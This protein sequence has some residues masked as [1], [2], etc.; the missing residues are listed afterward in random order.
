MKEAF[1][2]RFA[3]LSASASNWGKTN[4]AKIGTG[5]ALFGV[6]AIVVG[7][8]IVPHLAANAE[9]VETVMPRLPIIG[10]ASDVTDGA[11]LTINGQKV[12]LWGITA[13]G[14]TTDDGQ[15]SAAYLAALVANHPLTCLQTG[16]LSYDRTVV[17]C[18]DP[19]NRD[20][21]E[22]MVAGGWAT[23]R[24]EYSARYYAPSEDLARAQGRGLH[25]QTSG[26]SRAAVSVMADIESL[27][28][29]PASPHT[30][31]AHIVPRLDP[32]ASR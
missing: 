31:G 8:A 10:P 6:G 15:K 7:S 32:L 1:F 9:A 21:G 30:S 12:I 16:E 13:P 28:T 4:L 22:L 2:R 24:A 17:R 3:L 25:R 18:A 26:Q 23:D 11:S 20:V 27:P 19:W 14:S 29:P 5:G